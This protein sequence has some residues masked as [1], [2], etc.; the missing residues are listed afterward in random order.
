MDIP[1][2]K[3]PTV[4]LQEI[5]QTLADAREHLAELE[6][7]IRSLISQGVFDAVPRL[8][9]QTKNGREYLYLWFPRSRQ[10]PGWTGPKGKAK[11]YVGREP[12][13]VKNAKEW[14][15]RTRRAIELTQTK[16]A[17]ERWITEMEMEVWRLHREVVARSYPKAEINALQNEFEEV[18][19]W[20]T[21]P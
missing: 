10:H 11:M 5:I 19:Q 2:I 12:V 4:M 21:R 1:Q 15:E 7:E 16:E 9:W 14:I 8:D 6:A 17:L 18:A 3:T 13:K 20:R